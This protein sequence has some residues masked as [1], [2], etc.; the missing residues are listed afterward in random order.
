MNHDK[1]NNSDQKEKK[2][3]ENER[4]VDH[5]VNLV[6]RETRT[7]RHLEQYADSDISNPNNIDNAEKIQQQRKEE[8]EHLKDIIVHGENSS[9]ND[10]AN[11]EKRY[12][13]AEG[14]INHNADHMDQNALENAKEKQKHRKEQM[15]SYK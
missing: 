3:L 5:L 1:N 6:E 12:R 4:R 9:N 14:Y 13:Y 10:Q 2:C 11:L 8:V 7:E 15:E